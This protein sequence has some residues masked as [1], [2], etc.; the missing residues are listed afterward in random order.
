MLHRKNDFLKNVYVCEQKGKNMVNH[1]S[2]LF[3]KK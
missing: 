3:V 1:S 2:K